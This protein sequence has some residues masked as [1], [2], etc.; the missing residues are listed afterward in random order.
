VDPADPADVAEP[1]GGEEATA[2]AGLADDVRPAEAEEPVEVAAPS[3]VDEPVDGERAAE[4]GEAVVADG[5]V[6][7]EVDAAPVEESR[8][9]SG[10]VAGTAGEARP[11]EPPRRRWFRRRG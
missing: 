10:Q 1:A 2:P 8:A 3:T 4:D 11:D 9:A 5:S 7:A 6:G